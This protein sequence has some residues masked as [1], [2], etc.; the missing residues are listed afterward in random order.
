MKISSYANRIGGF[1]SV[2]TGVINDCYSDAKVKYDSNAAG[3]VFENTG[4]IGNSVAQKKTIGKEN[5][6]GFCYRNRGI[7]MESG[8]LRENGAEKKY[9]KK[10]SDL[11]LALDYEKITELTAK[12]GLGSRWKTPEEGDKR[13]EFSAEQN[14]NARA[15]EGKEVVEISSAEELFKISADIAG[16]DAYA[17]AC[18]YKLIKDINLKGKKWLPLGISETMAFSGVF[19]GNGFKIYN[20]KIDAKGLNYAGFFGYVKAA[21]VMNLTLDCIVKAA[22]GNTVGGMCGTNNGGE[23]SNCR[24]L[25][26]VHAEKCCGGFVGNNAGTIEK[27]C[28]IG[29]I[30]PIIPILLWLLPL[31]GAILL[32]LIAGII[33]L[34]INLNKSPYNPAII[35]PNGVPIVDDTPV[36]PPPAGSNRISFE[37]NQE[38]YVNS[39]T[40]VG[41]INYVNPKRSTQDVVISIK[42]SDAEL[43][44]TIGTTGRSAEDQAALEATEGYNP[45]KSY[46]ELYRSG[47][48]QIGYKLDLCQLSSLPN[49]TTLP[50]GDYE[51]I[52]A[53]DAYDPETNE[54]AVVN[55]QAPITV[56]IVAPSAAE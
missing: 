18:C 33:I 37:L 26:R 19:D 34:V 25:A 9:H 23:F 48:L 52:V 3:F 39:E 51:M 27:C 44:K 8:W 45:E 29:K 17:A 47:R 42:I 24:V 40:Q 10:Y 7:I 16:G 2:N 56:H 36:T 5:I 13:L 12:L 1:A 21:H 43:L 30:T 22:G 49:G 54:K 32:L 41:I 53:I 50:V 20:F 46:Q 31:F 4:M 35:D 6:G 55:A 11:D 28:F 15:T 14:G 38:V